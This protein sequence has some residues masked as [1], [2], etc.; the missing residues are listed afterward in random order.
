MQR[1]GPSDGRTEER[2]ENSRADRF[3]IVV[4]F[5]EYEVRVVLHVDHQMPDIVEESGDDQRVTGT[6]GP[7]QRGAL[8][9]VLTLGDRLAVELVALVSI[10]GEE[11]IHATRYV[12]GLLLRSR[13]RSMLRVRVESSMTSRQ[14]LGESWDF[15][16]GRF[17]RACSVV[18]WKT[19]AMNCPNW[20][21]PD[22]CVEP[23][24]ASSAS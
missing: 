18:M 3:V 4:I 7:R 16:G 13:C 2:G 22:T 11:F 10:Q 17:Q 23:V 8:E 5:I 15:E 21:P 6:R 1:D 14:P 9:R 24:S 19:L 12:H 20:Y